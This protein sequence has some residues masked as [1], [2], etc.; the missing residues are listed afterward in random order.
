MNCEGYQI[1]IGRMLD[2]ECDIR[3]ASG[4]FT[5]LGL[6]PDC[7]D[8]FRDLQ[9]LDALLG[10]V[11]DSSTESTPGP[12]GELRPPIRSHRASRKKTLVTVVIAGLSIITVGL[13]AS[14]LST[15]R[16]GSSEKIFLCR[17][18]AVVV[19]AESSPHSQPR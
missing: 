14:L 1:E 13:A 8:Y 4:V 19:T 5:H 10:A 12:I 7:R 3:N 6:C 18:P 11:A 2:G 16:H 17:L 9:K 15:A